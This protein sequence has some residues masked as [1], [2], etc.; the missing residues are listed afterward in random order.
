MSRGADV[1]STQ[2]LG[3]EAVAYARAHNMDVHI[4]NDGRMQ[5]AQWPVTP[6]DAERLMDA[7]VVHPH[8][9]WVYPQP[10]VWLVSGKYGVAGIDEQTAW[11]MWDSIVDDYMLSAEWMQAHN[12]VHAQMMERQRR[13]AW[14][15]DH[16]VVCQGG[17]EVVL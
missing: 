8:D 3:D 7:D 16:Q 6:D 4:Y 5:P 9:V 1:R 12:P 17:E 2:L 11:D 13:W 10:I 15:M 14:R